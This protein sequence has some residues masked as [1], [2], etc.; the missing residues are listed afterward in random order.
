M[1]L[2]KAACGMVRLVAQGGFAQLVL[3]YKV[4]VKHFTGLHCLFVVV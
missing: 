4:R 2:G 1:S 3:G